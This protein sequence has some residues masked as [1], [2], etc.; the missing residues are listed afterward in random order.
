MTRNSN[1]I[2]LMFNKCKNVFQCED[3]KLYYVLKY[4]HTLLNRLQMLLVRK[5]I[6]PSIYTYDFQKATKYSFYNQETNLR[7]I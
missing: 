2:V 3:K 5:L 4:F 7:L 6:P 1:L